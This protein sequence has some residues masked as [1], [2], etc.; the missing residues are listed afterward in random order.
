M[1]GPL[2]EYY[3]SGAIKHDGYFYMNAFDSIRTSYY[4]N[5]QV[6]ETGEYETRYDLKKFQGHKTGTWKYYY[7]DGTTMMEEEYTDSVMFLRSYYDQEK[8][9][10]TVS[11]GNGY[12]ERRDSRGTPREKF[13]YRNGL[14]DGPFYEWNSTGTITAEGAYSTGKRN[15]AWRKRLRRKPKTTKLG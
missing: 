13:T 9:E 12:V 15:G 14:W 5:G 1:H 7:S 2:K 3:E 11:N 10:Q 6:M 4:E 8:K